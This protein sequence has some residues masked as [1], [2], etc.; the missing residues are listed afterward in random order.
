MF[1]A[2]RRVEVF[3]LALAN[4][5]SDDV[6]IVW[7]VDLLNELDGESW[8][9]TDD[10]DHEG[11]SPERRLTEDLGAGLV[12]ELGEGLVGRPHAGPEEDE[13]SRDTS[14]ETHQPIPSGS[15]EHDVHVDNDN[16]DRKS[17]V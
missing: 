17:V 8:K 10:D 14:E 5:L 6:D 15:V 12:E 13:E 4:L 11:D 16:R 2:A 7:K 1:C 3:E 9:E